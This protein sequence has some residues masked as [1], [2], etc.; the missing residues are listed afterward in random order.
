MLK[1]HVII[2][3]TVIILFKKVATMQTTQKPRKRPHQKSHV[4]FSLSAHPCQSPQLQGAPPDK[5]LAAAS[6]R[7]EIAGSRLAYNFVNPETAPIAP[8]K[9]PRGSPPE[10]SPRRHRSPRRTKAGRLAPRSSRAVAAERSR[11]T[12]AAT[13][14][15]CIRS[16][17]PRFF[18]VRFCR[19]PESSA[20]GASPSGGHCR[21]G[22]G[23]ADTMPAAASLKYLR[24]PSKVARVFLFQPRA[25]LFL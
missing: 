6:S 21:A 1:I 25:G 2:T 12:S 14:P 23:R 11:R 13:K 10:S 16:R 4:H 7:S 9:I 15:R 3:N 18:A 20:A 19:E 17:G 22:D 8:E 24:G 5:R